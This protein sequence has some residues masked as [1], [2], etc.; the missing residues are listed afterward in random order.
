MRNIRGNVDYGRHA[1]QK[2]H[3]M[4]SGK[5]RHMLEY[6][7]EKHGMKAALINEAYTSQTCPKCLNRHKPSNRNYKC[8]VCGF[9]YHRDGV[10]AINIRQKQMYQEFVPVVGDMT[11]PVGIRYIA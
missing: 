3:G 10:G 6:K 1:N 8:P 7:C 9:E 5:I 2:I 11:P 4:T